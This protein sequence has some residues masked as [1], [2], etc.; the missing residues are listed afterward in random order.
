S[1]VH[2]DLKGPN[3]LVNDSGRAVIADFGMASI[4]PSRGG[5]INYTAPE[6]LEQG[7]FNRKET[8]MYAS[9]CV[10]YEIFVGKTPFANLTPW[11]I[12]QMV[13]AG[14]RPGRPSNSS[15]SWNA[16]GLTENI[17]ALFVMCW[18]ADPSKRPTIDVALQRLVQ[19]PSEDMWEVVDEF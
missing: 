10:G 14:Y 6:I 1:I 11:L 7:A 5:T 16:W 15:P 12:A 18:A 13:L 3:I 8:D 9:A 19:A 17:W 2:G 4:L